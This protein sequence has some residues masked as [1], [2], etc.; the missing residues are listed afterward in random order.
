MCGICGILNFDQSET[1]DRSM[2]G[3]MTDEL[4]HRGPDDEGYFVDG[5]VGLGHRRLSIID[6]DSGHQPMTSEDG[7]TVVAYNGEIYNFQ[8]LRERLQAKG[9][10]FSTRSDTE[11]IVHGYEEWG[12]GVVDELRGMFA[13]AI[14]DGRRKRLF[15]A[16]DRLGK[17]PLYYYH[18]RQRLI[19]A[20]EIK[21]ILKHPDVAREISAE[22][23]SDYLSL[24]YVPAPRTIFQ[25]IYKLPPGHWLLATDGTISV[26]EYWDVPFQDLQEW[27]ENG[28]AAT[29]YGVLEDAVRCRLVSDVPL[30]AFLSGGIDSSTVVSLMQRTSDS[31]VR[32]AS[33]GFSHR[34]YDEL[35]H[36]RLL[37]GTLNTDHRE[38]VVEADTVAI[39]P[40]LAWHLDEPHG[41]SSAVPTYYVS[42]M[43]RENVTVALSGDGGDE[44]FAGYTRRYF[45]DRLE[46]QIRGVIPAP[47]RKAVFSGLGRVYPKADWLPRPL[48]AK[49]LLTNLALSPERGFYNTMAAIPDDIKN[50]LLAPDVRQALNGHETFHVFEHYFQKCPSQDPLSRVQYVDMKTFLVDD[51]LMKVDKMSMANSLEVRCPLLDQNV[52][53]YVA[54]LPSGLK[55]RGRQ[56]K[57]IL[58]RAMADVVPAEIL[59]RPKQGFEVPLRHWLRGELKTFAR[60]V[61]FESLETD[62]FFHRPTVEKMWAMHQSGRRDWSTP[63]WAVL[64]FFLWRHQYQT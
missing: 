12:T 39:L 20:S 36:C 21:A 60:E 2:L 11:C 51:I 14:W 52:V 16:R 37:A 44:N 38:Y 9:H 45:Y 5:Q 31:P 49:S 29:V 19:F 57:Y 58:K 3:A 23:V 47:I 46:N 13:F 30:G 41:D 6:L 10:R 33:I 42:K 43:A 8:S 18:D 17:K 1:V 64:M 22:S 50:Q 25:K 27:D 26:Q 62:V 4:V 35:E 48:R 55:L 56:S 61:I 53:E 7:R 34:A 63:L 24:L 28:T 59:N 40:K 15:L 32:T 54:G